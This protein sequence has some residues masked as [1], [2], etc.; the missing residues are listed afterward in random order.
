G[1]ED[2]TYTEIR[3]LGS[4]RLPRWGKHRQVRTRDAG[5]PSPAN[6]DCGRRQ[7]GDWHRLAGRLG[8]EG[9]VGKGLEDGGRDFE[10]REAFRRCMNQAR[11]EIQLA[12]CSHLDFGICKYGSGPTGVPL[13]LDFCSEKAYSWVANKKRNN[14]RG[15]PTS[16]PR[17]WNQARRHRSS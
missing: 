4:C 14:T 11:G 17:F 5:A 15:Y 9:Q 6:S 3:Q 10:A 13:S 2:N 1:S 16:T 12:V 7:S 8:I